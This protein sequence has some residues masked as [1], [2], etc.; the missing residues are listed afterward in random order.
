MSDPCCVQ[1]ELSQY[2][3]HKT[4]RGSEAK[5]QVVWD[6]LFHLTLI[7]R[8]SVSPLHT[9]QLSQ[10][11]LQMLGHFVEVTEHLIT[12]SGILFTAAKIETPQYKRHNLK[13]DSLED[14]VC[15]LQ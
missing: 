11:T 7:S 8:M 3:N 6:A 9:C 4:I 15:N 1:Q 13:L 14:V 10:L 12:H 2:I 5:Q